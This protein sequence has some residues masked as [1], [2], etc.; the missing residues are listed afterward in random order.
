MM[1]IAE[2]FTGMIEVAIEWLQTNTLSLLLALAI[3]IIG[4]WLATKVVLFFGKTLKRAK[5]EDILVEFLSGIAKAVLILVVT[6]AAL[7]Q[8]GIDTTPL[9]ALI[10]AAGI[11]VGFALKDSLQNFA[12]GV[13]LIVFRPFHAGDF[14]EAGG[15]LGV[16]EKITTFSTTMRTG[17]NKEVIVPNGGIYGGTITNF[18]ARSTRRVDMVFG[19]SYDSDLRKAKTIL[20]DIIAA[21]ERVLPEPLPVIAV[22]ELADSSVNILVRPWVNSADYWTFYWDMQEKV[23]LTF[24]E[25]GISIPFP[26]MDVSIKKQE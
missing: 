7:G 21:D 4:R 19:I 8:L 23:K 6:V 10:G 5:F 9:I 13:M 26:Q 15:V 12:S 17:D 3:F 2:I 25:Q 24:D 11:A 18:S 16:V 14:I 1:E 20:A 22:G